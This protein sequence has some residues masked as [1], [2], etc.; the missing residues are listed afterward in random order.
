MNKRS[1]AV[2]LSAVVIAAAATAMGARAADSRS[3]ADQAL[4]SN[5]IHAIASD[6]DLDGKISVSSR[7]GEVTLDG[8]V[9]TSGQADRAERDAQHVEGVR[10]VQNLV[11]AN[12]G[13][14]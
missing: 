1:K 4:T 6:P 10:E 5:V 7:D 3:A 8:L 13:Q 12:V 11:R 14:D 2:L 9:A